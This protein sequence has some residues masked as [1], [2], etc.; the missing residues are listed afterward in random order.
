M[1]AVTTVS[2]LGPVHGRLQCRARP[3]VKLRLTGHFPREQHGHVRQHTS[4]LLGGRTIPMRLP[5]HGRA[6]VAGEGDGG[7]QQHAA[8]QASNGPC[9][10]RPP[11]RRDVL[12]QAANHG[13]TEVPSGAWGDVHSKVLAKNQHALAHR[14]H[15]RLGGRDRL[16]E[17]HRDGVGDA[18][19][20]ACGSSAHPR[21]RRWSPRVGP[22]TP[23]PPAPRPVGQ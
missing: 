19:R 7:G 18:A 20:A 17:S 12:L 11:A 8:R 21:T 4:P 1:V 9:H 22:A 10:R 2:M 6:Q 3:A 13:F 14:S 23:E 15:V 16:T 5:G